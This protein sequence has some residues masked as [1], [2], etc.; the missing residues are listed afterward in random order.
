MEPLMPAGLAQQE[1]ENG[2]G[3][4]T[5]AEPSFCWDPPPRPL[6][7]TPLPLG[8]ILPPVQEGNIAYASDCRSA[9]IY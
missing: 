7:R 4:G 6:K 3:R 1:D 2:G 5:E 8:R 9:G